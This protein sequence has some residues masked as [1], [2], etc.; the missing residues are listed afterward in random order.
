MLKPVITIFYLSFILINIAAA[1]NNNN[2]YSKIFA[3][4]LK[5]NEDE[6]DSS[7]DFRIKI[8][9][10]PYI[11]DYK[12][13][14][15]NGRTLIANRLNSILSQFEDCSPNGNPRFIIATTINLVS[16]KVISGSPVKFSNSY[17][18]TLTSADI[19]SKTIFATYT[20]T[21]K[22]LDDSPVKTFINGFRAVNFE[23]KEFIK[24]L[25][26]T[27]NQIL[28]Y[29]DYG[30][31]NIIN[32]AQAEA[33]NKHFDAAYLIL[34]N[35]PE[36]SSNC[37]KQTTGKM[38]ENARKYLNQNCKILVEKMKAELEKNPAPHATQFSE[39]AMAYYLLIDKKSTCF[40]EADTFYRNYLN[41]LNP[42]LKN[43]WEI[44]QKEFE[45][46]IKSVQTS[47][48][49]DSNKVNSTANPYFYYLNTRMTKAEP[50]AYKM[51]IKKYHADN[52]GWFSSTFHTEEYEPFTRN[53]Y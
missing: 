13:L 23:N 35:I 18:L 1:N 12:D 48:A 8:K 20:T 11:P 27:Q 2:V 5:E 31:A 14:G 24:F 41:G 7:L 47:T 21:I 26:K 4:D 44:K 43:E 50:S 42:K 52:S 10:T 25:S 30:C 38:E 34:K 37:L 33:E 46:E 28:K 9:L 49:Q 29:Y 32:D 40:A 3:Q 16:K 17:E 39:T 15:V 53:D 45:E 6:I 19:V 36:K 51:L 22:G